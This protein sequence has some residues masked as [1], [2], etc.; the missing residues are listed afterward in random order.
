MGEATWILCKH[1]IILSFYKRLLSPCRHW[2]LWREWK[3]WGYISEPILCGYQGR[4][5]FDKPIT[6]LSPISN[7]TWP[8]S[9]IIRQLLK[10]QP[11]PSCYKTTP[12]CRWAIIVEVACSEGAYSSSN[13]GTTYMCVVITLT[14]VLCQQYRSWLLHFQLHRS[15]CFGR[16]FHISTVSVSFFSSS[17]TTKTKARKPFANFLS[18]LWDLIVLINFWFD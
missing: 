13:V 17:T 18:K 6:P 9:Y 5:V 8:L 12:F 7:R 3:R 10:P 2:C 16:C 14:P 11:S 1:D 4:L 15:S